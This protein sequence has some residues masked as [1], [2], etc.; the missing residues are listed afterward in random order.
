[1]PGWAAVVPLPSSAGSP[2]GHTRV[3]HGDVWQRSDTGAQPLALGWGPEN[4]ENAG[5]PAAQLRAFVL[6]E[7][8]PKA[9]RQKVTEQGHLVQRIPK[10]GRQRCRPANAQPLGCLPRSRAGEQPGQ[11]EC[12]ERER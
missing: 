11:K 12:K 8:V 1:M 3:A 9:A 2:A 4:P 6:L 10:P 5:E 7:H